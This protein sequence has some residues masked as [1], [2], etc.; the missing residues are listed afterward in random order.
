MKAVFLEE[1]GGG[2]VY[3]EDYVE[4]PYRK[5][6]CPSC[7]R[8]VKYVYNGM[9]ASIEVVRRGSEE[10]RGGDAGRRRRTAPTM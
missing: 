2:H 1:G 3:G 4:Y 9:Q 5:Y 6:E 8:V 10:E 7:G